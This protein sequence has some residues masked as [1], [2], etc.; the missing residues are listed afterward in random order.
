MADLIGPAV[1]HARDGVEVTAE[2]A[3]LLKILEPILTEYPETRAI[4]AP[5]GA[6][7]GEGEVFRF[8]DLADALER[9][10]AEGP[11]PFYR[12]EVA[13]AIAAW[14]TDRGGTLGRAD[15]AGYEAV[16]RRPVRAA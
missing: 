16:A 4:Y 9:Y 7:L 1:S 5:S 10:G 14:V 3:Y 6:I 13:E 15:L 11:E 8:P 12:G 2:Q